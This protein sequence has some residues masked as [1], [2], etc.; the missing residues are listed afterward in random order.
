MIYGPFTLRACT[1]IYTNFLHYLSESSTD[2]VPPSAQ[3]PPDLM[4]IA[5]SLRTGVVLDDLPIGSSIA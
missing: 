2:P 3:A 5:P 4:K 1:N